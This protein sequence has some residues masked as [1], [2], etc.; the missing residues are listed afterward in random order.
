MYIHL[1]TK[2]GEGQRFAIL[3]EPE[4]IPTPKVSP[5]DNDK[6]LQDTVQSHGKAVLARFEEKNPFQLEKDTVTLTPEEFERD[7]IGD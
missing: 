4:F 3:I 6:E 1:K 5:K 7:W 2:P